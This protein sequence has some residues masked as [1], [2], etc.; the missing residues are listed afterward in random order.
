ME[1]VNVT[2]NDSKTLANDWLVKR[3]KPLP[4][5]KDLPDHFAVYGSLRAKE[6]N[7]KRFPKL[8]AVKTGLVIDGF[9][10]FNLG[11]YP[12]IVPTEEKEDKLVV[13]IIKT[14]DLDTKTSVH[15]MEIYAGYSHDII[16]IDGIKCNI[17][18]FDNEP[19]GRDVVKSG[20]WSKRVTG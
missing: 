13:D 16:T 2:E 20:D 18:F 7:F 6:Y 12:C 15:M 11:A 17:Y 19:K 5:I 10:L 4:D 9:K 14:D 3:A 1:K 8:E